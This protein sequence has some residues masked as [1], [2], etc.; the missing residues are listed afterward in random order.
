MKIEALSLRGMTRFDDV[1]ALDLRDIPPGLIAVTGENGAGKTTVMEAAIAALYRTFPSRKQGELVDY[2][3]KSDAFIEV[4]FELEG[5]GTY[6]ARVNIDGPHRKTDAVLVQRIDGRDRH[7]NDGKVSTY[8]TAVGQ[9]LPRLDVLLASVVAAQNREGSFIRLKPSAR[10]TL[11]AALLGAD[12]Y[13]AWS[14]RAKQAAALTTQAID[15]LNATREVV[16]RD[17]SPHLLTELDQLTTRLLTE[18][19]DLDARRRTLATDLSEAE[20]TLATYQEQAAVYTAARTRADRLDMELNANAALGQR[21]ADAQRRL[22]EEHDRDGAVIQANMARALVAIDAEMDAHDLVVEIARIDLTLQSAL[23]EIETRLANNRKVLEAADEIQAAV[24]AV[25]RYDAEIAARNTEAVDVTAAISTLRDGIAEMDRLIANGALVEQQL[26]R[27]RKDATLLETVPCG[28]AEPYATC[29]FLAQAVAA[30]GT[31]GMLAGRLIP[32]QQ[33][34]IER[35]ERIVEVQRRQTALAG[36]VRQLEDIGEDRRKALA[37]AAR[38]SDLAIAKERIKAHEERQTELQAEAETARAEARTRDAARWTAMTERRERTRTEADAA[39]ATLTERIDA[40]RAD[41]IKQQHERQTAR[42]ALE[43]ERVALSA[44]ME[45]TQEAHTR[46]DEQRSIL[47]VRRRDWDTSTSAASRLEAETAIVARRRAQYEDRRTELTQIN[48]WL[49]ALQTDLVEWQLLQK[50]F[51]R[52]GLQVI[53]IDEAGPTVSAYCND[54]LRTCFGSRFSVE[55]VTQEAKASKGKDNS[56]MKEAFELK[57]FDALR[58]GE[59][60]DLADLSGGEQ[61]LVDEA[62]KSAIALLVNTRN[63]QPMRTCWRDET[64]GAL[65]TENA[66]RYLDMLRRV[67][68]LGGF[69]H[70]WFVSHN[71]DIAAQ[72]DAQIVVEN[73]TVRVELPPYGRAVAA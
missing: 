36:V 47:T 18:A 38:A 43:S 67:Q 51:G 46:A 27:A 63:Q 50:T 41:L 44:T 54:L 22:Q 48:G 62:L 20:T 1:V 17:C 72:A 24:E 64:T 49:A 68:Q 39:L 7:L 30:K 61:V 58:G 55:L 4:S 35:D 56:T 53:E 70:V 60:R 28:G 52:D 26:E 10:R 2:A 12:R 34:K 11:F 8:E 23:H 16:Q 5:Q 21:D 45:A 3:T 69:H 6:R 40:R 25:A 73:G 57:V 31:L 65:D 9:L 14:E 33:A 42:I 19:S 15:R 13:D 66:Q 37:L 71:P 59:P 29:G 32:A